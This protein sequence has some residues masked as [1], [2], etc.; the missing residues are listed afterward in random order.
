MLQK[1][2]D[3]GSIPYGTAI[4]GE[5]IV[6]GSLVKIT[7]VDGVE[8]AWL[9]DATEFA[10]VLGFAYKVVTTDE[11]TIKSNDTIALGERLVVYTLVKNNVW[12]TTQ[13]VADAGLVAG[14][15]ATIADDGK[16][17]IKATED[18]ARFVVFQLQAAGEAYNDAML[19]VRVL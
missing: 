3:N 19:N 7:L 12:A 1:R 2:I 8:T 15:L 18:T 14:A 4:A 13:F 16:I 5:A 6:K 17:K 9:A 10:D 11:G